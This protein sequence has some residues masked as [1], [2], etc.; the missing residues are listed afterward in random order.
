MKETL[1]YSPYGV[2]TGALM[3]F[4]IHFNGEV[5]DGACKG[6]HLGRGKRLYLPGLM[7]FVSPDVLSPFSSGGLNV[8]AYCSGDPVNYTDPS[9]MMRALKP[10]G[11]PLTFKQ[12]VRKV[13][14][15]QRFIAIAKDQATN[16]GAISQG[17]GKGPSPK[18]VELRESYF[19]FRNKGMPASQI[20]NEHP[21]LKA[22]VEHHSR[23]AVIG[24][25]FAG[26]RKR[27]L[28]LP[29]HLEL[30]QR[31]LAPILDYMEKFDMSYTND[32]L[33]R[34]IIASGAVKFGL[35]ENDSAELISWIR[36]SA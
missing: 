14:N 2:L 15:S 5:L 1:V 18:S 26:A 35:S 24:R 12:A 21:E 11:T 9:G 4:S 30:R 25:L 32:T 10:S 8:Y 28:E 6:Y 34:L 3:H 23:M 7:R 19:D 16:K 36:K 27:N 13:I 17:P 22:Y 31:A 20:L 33:D 29:K